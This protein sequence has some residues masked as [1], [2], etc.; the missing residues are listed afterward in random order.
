MGKLSFAPNAGQRKPTN[1]ADRIDQPKN[2]FGEWIRSVAGNDAVF[3]QFG[4]DQMRRYLGNDSDVPVDFDPR[5]IQFKR[6]DDTI[7]TNADHATVAS[8]LVAA[9]DGFRDDGRDSAQTLLLSTGERATVRLLNSTRTLASISG[10]LA[11]SR[12]WTTPGER[13]IG[14]QNAVSNSDGIVSED[15]G[16]VPD[17]R[18]SITMSGVESLVGPIPRW[19]ATWTQVYDAA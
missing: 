16:G 15:T 1:G 7:H 12:L 17:T 2:T 4:R 5:R 3:G 14:Y 8:T 11:G 10:R 19:N 6:N 13:S 18:I 9:I